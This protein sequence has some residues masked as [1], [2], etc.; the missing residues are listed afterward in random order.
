MA[1]AWLID[2][3]TVKLGGEQ[4]LISPDQISCG[5][6]KGLWV[7]DQQESGEGIGRLQPAGRALMFSDDVRMGDHR[8]SNPYVQL[9]GTFDVKVS[10]IVTIA[11]ENESSKVI[12]VKLG[13]IVKHP[14]FTEPLPLLGIDRGDFSQDAPPRLL[15]K[16][17][18]DWTVDQVLH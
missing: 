10:K 14:C 4:V 18:G 17:K 5:E 8:F 1:A 6:R 12:E 15:L 11:D 16:M 2:S 7:V 3:S 9:R 13:I